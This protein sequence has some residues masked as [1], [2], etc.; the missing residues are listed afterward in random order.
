MSNLPAI[1]GTRFLT[2]P[3]ENE[4]L[5]EYASQGRAPIHH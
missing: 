1:M 3:W 4:H 5:P 2:A